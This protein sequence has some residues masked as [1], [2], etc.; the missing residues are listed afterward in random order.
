ML[1]VSGWHIKYDID[2]ELLELFLILQKGYIS[3]GINGVSRVECHTPF[4][5]SLTPQYN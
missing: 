3:S 1:I 5:H 2:S 4:I